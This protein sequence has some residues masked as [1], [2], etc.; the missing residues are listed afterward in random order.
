[1]G[2]APGPPQIPAAKA[3]TSFP[4]FSSNSG[5]ISDSGTFR[6]HK[7]RTAGLLFGLYLRSTEELRI[8]SVV[9]KGTN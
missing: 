9:G 2:D 4:S 3:S 5:L 1:M 8:G 6:M 7:S